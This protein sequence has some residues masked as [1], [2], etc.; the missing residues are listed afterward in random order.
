MR[1]DTG[2]HVHIP[3]LSPGAQLVLPV[4]SILDPQDPA[5]VRAASDALLSIWRLEG[6]GE[7]LWLQANTNYRERNATGVVGAASEPRVAAQPADAV[8][9]RRWDPSRKESTPVPS[10]RAGAVE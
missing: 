6:S 3:I 8:T 2:R 9:M 5:T 1:F 7:R 10:H 4:V